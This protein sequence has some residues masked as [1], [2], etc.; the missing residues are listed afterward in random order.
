MKSIVD[1]DEEL[2]AHCPLTDYGTVSVNTNQYN[3]CEG[4]SCAE[5][6]ENYVET[7]EEEVMNHKKVIFNKPATI[8]IWSDNT[9]TVVKCNKNDKFKKKVGFLMAYFQ[10]NSGLTKHQCAKLLKE[11]TE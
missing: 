5:A 2:C 9:K 8:V 6:Y 10:K 3:L 1:L 4:A 7:L 11:L